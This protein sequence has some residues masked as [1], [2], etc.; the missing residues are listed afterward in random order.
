MYGFAPVKKDEAKWVEKTDKEIIDAIL[1]FRASEMLELS[2]ATTVC[3]YAPIAVLLSALKGA[4]GKLVKYA[5]SYDI[6]KN[7]DAIVGYAGIVF[8]K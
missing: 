6:S 2:K 1:G 5:T 4:K 7:K 8:E 3:G